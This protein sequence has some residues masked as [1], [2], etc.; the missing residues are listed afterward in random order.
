M[1]PYNISMLQA[2]LCSYKPCKRVTLALRY[3]DEL[4]VAVL[5]AAVKQDPQAMR[6]DYKPH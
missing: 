6:P 5:E 1:M 2:K 4:S 3:I